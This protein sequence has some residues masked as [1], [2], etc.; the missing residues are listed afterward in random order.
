MSRGLVSLL[1][2]AAIL[3][4]NDRANSAGAIAEGISP[5]GVIHGY[6]YGIHSNAP[7]AD[8]AKAAALGACKATPDK[9]ADPKARARCAVV[10]TFTN[11][12]AAIAL[13][14]KAGTPGVGWAIGDTQKRADDE[15]LA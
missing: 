7:N 11:K 4:A 10:S 1:A 6:S 14:P 2:L 15:A 9:V 5:T 12:C 8:A 3:M 13:D